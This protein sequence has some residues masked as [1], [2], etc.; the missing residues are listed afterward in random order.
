MHRLSQSEIEFLIFKSM[1]DQLERENAGDDDSLHSSQ[2]R[3]ITHLTRFKI[4]DAF[5]F[6]LERPSIQL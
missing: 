2:I 5:P 1:I 6:V 4:N 3:Y